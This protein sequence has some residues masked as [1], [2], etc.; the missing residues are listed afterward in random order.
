[1]CCHSVGIAHPVPPAGSSDCTADRRPVFLSARKCYKFKQAI[2]IDGGGKMPIK[3]PET[4]QLKELLNK[5]WMTHDAMWFYNCVQEIGIEKANRIN[6]AA[7]RAMAAVEMKRMKRALGV[8]EVKAFDQLV[9]LFEASM[10]I[11]SG[12]FM[13]YKFIY[14]GQNVFNFDQ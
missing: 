5:D 4:K 3:T 11:V 13:K 1:M 12:D 10:Y 8:T 2:I 14:P 6:R 9:E 7:V